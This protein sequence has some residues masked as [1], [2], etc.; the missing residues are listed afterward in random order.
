[1][2]FEIRP[3]TEAGQRYVELCEKHA[4]DFAARAEQH[5]RE[6][7]FPF[8]NIEALKQSGV[9]SAGLPEELGG[10]GIDHVQDLVAGMNRLARGDG[11]TAI[12]ANMHIGAPYYVTRLWRDAQARQSQ[13]EIDQAFGILQTLA[14]TVTCVCQTEAGSTIGWPL[15]E[16]TPTEGGWLLNGRKI[17]GT[18]SMAADILIVVCRFPNDD[19][20]YG[21]A[22]AFVPKGSSGLQL[23]D[24]WDA[25]GMRASGSQS[26]EFH[27][28]FVPTELF[29]PQPDPWG[30]L[31]AGNLVIQLSA[32]LSLS[33]A[34]VGI[35]EQAREI[36]LQQIT[37]R[38][39]APSNRFVAERTGIQYQFAELEIDLATA[40]SMIE[41]TADKVDEYLVSHTE[42]ELEMDVLHDLLR[43]FQCTKWVT[44]RKA[45][46]VVDRAL[47]LSGGTGYFNSSPLSRLYRD[48]RAGPFMQVFS[49]NEAREY[50]GRIALGL[51]PE[52]DL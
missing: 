17:F 32:N 44:N 26:M 2:N 31:D 42:S 21:W 6:A 40:R 49:P 15:T 18:L 29:N 8:E 36:V 1:M 4:A 3:A 43:D 39:K 45:I 14:V 13:D 7:S 30:T 23:N 50:I 16:A 37:T 52:I 28:C 51:G 5:D 47:T 41:R 9:L 27:D 35:A 38:R 22:F 34:M 48:V 19:G 25:L 10:F 33:A 24:D 46:D 12:A 11:S 20:E